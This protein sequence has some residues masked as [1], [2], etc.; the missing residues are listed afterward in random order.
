MS[1]VFDS[2]PAAASTFAA[3]EL[4]RGG[5]LDSRIMSGWEYLWLNP[6]YRILREGHGSVDTFWLPL[7]E[8]CPA[9]I[10]SFCSL[11]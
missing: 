6:S 9:L 7:V 8:R 5:F 11:L 10:Y 4:T 3:F 1:L 2:I